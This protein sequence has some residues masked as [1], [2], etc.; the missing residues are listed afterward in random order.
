MPVDTVRRAVNQII[1]QTTYPTL[2]ANV[3]EDHLARSIGERLGKRLE[4]ALVRE[5]VAGGP[6]DT[7]GLVPARRGARGEI[8]LGDLITAVGGVRVRQVED[9]IAAVL[10]KKP[11]DVLELA[12]A[13]GGDPSRPARRLVSLVSRDALKRVRAGRGPR[14]RRGP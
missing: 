8:V 9:L 4:G 7:A 11:G 13:R 1:R 3:Y 2:G 10:E 6:A 5:V 12:V 14:Q